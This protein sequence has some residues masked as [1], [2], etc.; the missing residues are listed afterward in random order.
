MRR[1]DW[2][3]VDMKILKYVIGHHLPVKVKMDWA[4]RRA[5]G[6]YEVRCGMRGAGNRVPDVMILFNICSNFVDFK[7]TN[8]AFKVHDTNLH[9]MSVS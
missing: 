6:G 4:G 9:R 8:G 3:D 7:Y 2:C 5:V 1:S